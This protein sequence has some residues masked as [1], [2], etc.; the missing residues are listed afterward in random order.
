MAFFEQKQ[1]GNK[2]VDQMCMILGLPSKRIRKITVVGACNDALRIEIEQLVTVDQSDRIIK[3]VE[4]MQED[5][6]LDDREP[7]PTILPK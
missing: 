2:F 7:E 3:L 5:L 6:L 1:L 4:G